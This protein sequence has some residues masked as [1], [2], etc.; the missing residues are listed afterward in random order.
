MKKQILSVALAVV[1][2]VCL[3]GCGDTEN[4]N[5]DTSMFALIET[6]CDWQ[7]VYHK[8]TKVMYAVSDG[9]YN[10]GIF[11]PLYNADGTLQIYEE[12]ED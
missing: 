7:I 12:S 4:V 10:R 5:D 1:M 3:V 8:E 6:T 9:D 2:A 11:T